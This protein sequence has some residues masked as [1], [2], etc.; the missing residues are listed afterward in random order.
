MKW[1]VSMRSI[2]RRLLWLFVFTVPWD[3][4]AFEGLGALSRVAGVAALGMALLTTAIEGRFRK[5]TAI[6]AIASAYIGF[7]AFSLLWTIAYPE[8]VQLVFTAVQILGS[9]WVLTEF[10]RT[11]DE[12][13]SLLV[14][15]CLGE[16]IPLAGILNSYRTGSRLMWSERYTAI[17][18][19][20]DDIGLTLVIGVP[21]AWHLMMSYSGP[22][23]RTVRAVGL[24]Y[25]VLTPIA[26]LLTG[27]RGAAIALV[28]A[29]SIV[30]LTLPRQSI[31]SLVLTAA[32]LTA[33]A[34]TATVVV[35]QR[36]WA[37]ILTI[38]TEILEGGA[39]TG[40]A[41]I[42]KAGISVMPE[43]PFLGAGA[44]AFGTAVEPILHKRSGA[45]NLVIGLLVELGIVG[46]L[47]YAALLGACAM[48]ILRMPPP[49][50]K[51]WAV[52][53][54]CWL[55]GVMSL[56][57]EYRKVTWLLFGFVAAESAAGNARR[58]VSGSRAPAAEAAIK[59]RS[60]QPGYLRSA[61]QR[62]IR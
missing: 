44:S 58:R 7:T 9:V 17:G 8:T 34:A 22:L 38:K 47:I 42:W 19:N 48:A 18:L 53:M 2:T 25:F 39:M 49:D 5:P 61:H 50:R 21:I 56:N 55:V 30:P 57:W 10:T 4:V 37:R 59:P 45:H 31:R 13:Q 24:I 62:A 15:F 28:V 54:L 27:T 32:L 16:L 20:A 46:F 23:R 14:A 1:N 41:D 33:I 43:H 29:L 12:Q 52:L 36:M 26:V 11:H 60:V 6:L 40:R 3:V 35:P 51:L